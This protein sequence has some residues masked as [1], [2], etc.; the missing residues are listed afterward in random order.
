M[1]NLFF[2][3][4]ILVVFILGC[5]ME[6]KFDVCIQGK[7]TMRSACESSLVMSGGITLGYSGKTGG[8]DDVKLIYTFSNPEYFILQ[9]DPWGGQWKI[10]YTQD[11]LFDHTDGFEGDYDFTRITCKYGDAEDFVDTIIYDKEDPRDY[12][13]V[14][15]WFCG[16]DSI[17]FKLEPSFP[18]QI[19]GDITVY[20]WETDNTG[21]TYLY[22][23]GVLRDNIR[24]RTEFYHPADIPESKI[25]MIKEEYTRLALNSIQINSTAVFEPVR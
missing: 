25:Q 9:D 16:S 20:T 22:D 19:S 2:V 15:S 14:G 17:T 12:D 10:I 13:L 4:T 8:A 3:S 11:N 5:S 23:G 1:K 7:D 21:N 24:F 6:E 18:V